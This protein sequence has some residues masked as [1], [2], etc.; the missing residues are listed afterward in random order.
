MIVTLSRTDAVRRFVVAGLAVGGAIAAAAQEPQTP[1]TFRGRTLLVPVDVRVLDRTGTPITDLTQR[2]FVVLENGVV[3]KISHFQTQALEPRPVE[4]ANPVRWADRNTPV[5]GQEH[6][7]FLI[8]LGRGRLQPP[9]KGLD[10]ALRLVRERL[11][12]QDRVAVVGWNRATD[13]TT[14]HEY[15]ARVLERYKDKHERIEGRLQQQFSGL[16]A[17]YGG[18]KISDQVQKEIDAVFQVPG[19]PEARTVLPG[20]FADADR[21]ASDLRRTADALQRVEVTAGRENIMSEA[22]TVADLMAP[23][24]SFD[25]FAATHR[26]TLQ[27]LGKLYAGIEYLRHL[28]GEK[29]LIFFSPEGLFLPRSEDDQGLAA[30]AAD[31]RVVID[32]IHTGG[33]PQFAPVAARGMAAPMGGRAGAPIS[34]P[35]G[36]R[37]GG[38]GAMWNV[39]TSRTVAM[40]TGGYFSGM[41]YARDAIDRIDT[42]SRFQ[43]VLGYYPT[44]AALDNRFRRIVVRVNRPGLIVEYRRGYFA[45]DALPPIDRRSFMTYSRI[46]AAGGI[47]EPIKDLPVALK[48]SA[49]TSDAGTSEILIDLEIDAT[50]VRFTEVDGRHEAA[51]NIAMFCADGRQNLVGELWQNMSLKP[52]D[53]LYQTFLADGIRHT[54]RVP[55]R[56]LVRYVKVVVYDYAGD[57]VGSAQ[58]DLPE[59]R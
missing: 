32:I 27:D 50:R 18:N 55:V 13:F 47:P 2:D 54:A 6:R 14:D 36:G 8:V 43:Y 10:G 48:A 37:G 46:A 17:V 44:N 42:A 26:A 15:V 11:L 3:Q 57:R 7:T 1:Q 30:Q 33:V 21:L 12:P 29:H 51:L 52:L 19:G 25:E 45:R 34:M 24:M 41:L 39:A 49:A 35:A 40:Q 5:V 22:D 59:R 20:S 58:V 28:A 23:G 31:A 4:G 9:A 38:R 16:A 53:A 56:G